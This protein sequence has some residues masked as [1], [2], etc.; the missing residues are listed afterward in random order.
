MILRH[1]G[2]YRS[3]NRPVQR[4]RRGQPTPSDRGWWKPWA[5]IFLPG[6]LLLLGLPKSLVLMSAVGVILYLGRR[7]IPGYLR[8]VGIR[9]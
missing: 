8:R 2:G 7:K 6:G 4:G 1:F 3:Q 9:V 5:L